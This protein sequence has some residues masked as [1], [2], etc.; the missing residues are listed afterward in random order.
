MVG[1]KEAFGRR[2]L[3]NLGQ[4][5]SQIYR[6]LH[7]DV[8]S[9]SA[10]RVVDVG[11]VSGQQH[12]SPA[13]GSG[14]SSYIG[15]SR[16]R[17]G[18]MDPEVRPIRGYKRVAEVAQ[19]GIVGPTDRRLGHHDTHRLSILQP[20]QGVDTVSVTEQAPWCLLGHL[21]LSDQVAD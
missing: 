13:I 4:F 9:L 12:P 7:A 20:A 2:L 21:D 11:R 6:I 8:E 5:P 17:N 16:N 18:T 1:V 14:L 10:R 15:E 3:D 19:S